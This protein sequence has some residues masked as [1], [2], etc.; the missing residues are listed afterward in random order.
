MIKTE[1]KEKKFYCTLIKCGS[2]PY[3]INAQTAKAKPNYTGC[4]H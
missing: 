3:F 2:N 4:I 1:Q